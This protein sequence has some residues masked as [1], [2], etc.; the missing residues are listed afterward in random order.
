[1][2]YV[3]LLSVQYVMKHYQL[4]MRKLEL[5]YQQDLDMSV[6][7]VNLVSSTYRDDF[8]KS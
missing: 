7:T 1:M 2:L 8:W 5:C 4:L 6:L 3:A